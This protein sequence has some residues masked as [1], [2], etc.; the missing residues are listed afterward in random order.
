MLLPLR[1]TANTRDSSTVLQSRLRQ[2]ESQKGSIRYVTEEAL[3]EDI[4][5]HPL[6]VGDDV[7]K[8]GSDQDNAEDSP[9]DHRKKIWEARK[10]MMEQLRYG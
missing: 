7:A 9:D 2:I 1:P 10:E 8:D 3:R 6:G 4:R 5:N